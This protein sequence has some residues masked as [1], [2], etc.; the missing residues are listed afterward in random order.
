MTDLEK[1]IE[2][3]RGF[4]IDCIV[5]K[6]D[7]GIEIAFVNLASNR[8]EPYE[9]TSKKFSG[10]PGFGS[11]IRFYKNGKFKRQSFWE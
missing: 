2:L 8:V 4:G 10:Y 6:T 1:F 11:T 9:T 7:T 5:E 3:Y